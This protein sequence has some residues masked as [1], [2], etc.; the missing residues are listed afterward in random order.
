MQCEDPQKHKMCGREATENED[1]SR[2]VDKGERE[3]LGL[4]KGGGASSSVVLDH[5]PPISYK[6]R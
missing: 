2:I 6:D 4:E 3:A 5:V 1:G